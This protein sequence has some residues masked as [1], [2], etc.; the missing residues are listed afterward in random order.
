M[1]N[2]ICSFLYFQSKRKKT[3]TEIL[4]EN[5]ATLCTIKE[6]RWK[7]QRFA[8]RMSQFFV[9]LRAQKGCQILTNFV[10][11]LGE[12]APLAPAFMSHHSRWC[13]VNIGPL[14]RK[15][16]RHPW[17]IKHVLI[18]IRFRPRRHLLHQLVQSKHIKCNL[19]LYHDKRLPWNSF[20]FSWNKT[21]NRT[22]SQL[23]NRI[24]LKFN[25]SS[26]AL[27]TMCIS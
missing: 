17:L 27:L 12:C 8:C 3:S 22:H 18:W 23:L 16:V 21:S 6:T 11:C 10:G 24:I 14:A 2:K 4:A 1:H 15:V 26:I 13:W 7:V 25:S 19:Y 5:G 20:S 9:I